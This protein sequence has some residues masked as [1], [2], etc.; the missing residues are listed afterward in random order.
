M[1]EDN[2]PTVEA[3]KRKKSTKQHLRAQNAKQMPDLAKRIQKQK[4]REEKKSMASGAE[5]TVDQ[6]AESK[7]TNPKHKK[8]QLNKCWLPTH[9]W[10]A[11][12]AQM[13]PPMEP[14]WRFAIP[15]SP[16]EKTARVTGRA[17]RLRGCV[18]WDMSYVATIG[19]EGTE[20]S[21]IKTLRSLRILEKHLS[22]AAGLAWRSGFRSY[23]AW[24]GE[25]PDSQRLI[26][27]PIFIWQPQDADK[28]E[29]RIFVRVL[30]SAF[31]QLWEEL[32]RLGKSQEP[33]V[34]VEDLR[35]AIGSIDITG[36]AALE[37]LTGVVHPVKSD[38]QYKVASIWSKLAAIQDSHSVPYGAVMH[39]SACDPRLGQPH[40]TVS[41]DHLILDDDA[42]QFITTW[43]SAENYIS[44]SIFDIVS[45]QK[46]V[47]NLQTQSAINK[48]KGA[49]LPGHH[50]EVL[51]NDPDIP[52]LL[53]A[54]NHG[55][56]RQAPGSWTILMPWNFILPTW[57]GL[58]HY[59]LSTGGNPRFGGLDE[60]RQ[61][62][63]EDN[64]AWFPGDFP[65][66]AAGWRWEMDQ[67]EKRKKE[68]DRKPKSKRVEWSTLNLGTDAKGELGM[69]WACDWE[70]LCPGPNNSIEIDIISTTDATTPL[71]LAGICQI[72]TP[73]LDSA[74]S[75]PAKGLTTVS[76]ALANKGVPSPCARIYR[77]P[78]TNPALQTQWLNQL[79]SKKHTKAPPPRSTSSELPEA[80]PETQLPPT[81]S[82]TTSNSTQADHPANPPAS[83]LIGF[84][85]AGNFNL[86][87]GRGTG[88]G[89]ILWPRIVDEAKRNKQGILS[90]IC[91]VRDAGQRYGRIGIWEVIV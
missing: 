47:R 83:D 27:S 80:I 43:P 61:L 25:G 11:K 76:I 62:C 66:T 31:L 86:A 19:M 24:V 20:D 59:P 22:G 18:A 5:K 34:K 88:V 49:A 79:N 54:N 89:C 74:E 90:G 12:R 57:H 4:E 37:S 10:H 53:L 91:I 28:L 78:T 81:A 42:A 72:I 29:R 40:Q 3:K 14:L 71:P 46:A 63:F 56:K 15:L 39:L 13:T 26:A 82:N 8:R 7:P 55:T 21:I 52:I 70:Y 77:L 87:Q 60:Q 64:R 58:M 84:V 48:R 45:R 33:P 9:V 35:F 36:P 17:S 51:P 67:R 38:D 30:P 65:G 6:L 69:G 32:L 85:T 50:P 41:K 68:W 44:T 2:T 1:K 23:S 73:T 16:T 75:F